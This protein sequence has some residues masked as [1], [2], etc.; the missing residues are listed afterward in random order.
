MEATLHRRLPN[1]T[2][3]AHPPASERKE[4]QSQARRPLR[5]AVETDR[6]PISR[7]FI[8]RI[9]VAVFRGQS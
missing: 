2:P 5:R 7:P 8:T 4:K 3:Q 6:D 1:L 9:A